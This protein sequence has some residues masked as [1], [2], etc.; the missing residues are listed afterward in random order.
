[1]ILTRDLI[2]L[3]FQNLSL[4]KVRSALTSL[5]VIFGVG[6]VIAMLAIAEG[7]KRRALEQ[8]ERMG[9]DRIMVTGEKP[10][11]E[12]IDATNS[13]GSSTITYGLT[14]ADKENI[15]KMDNVADVIAIWDQDLP[16][17]RGLN[18]VDVKLVGVEPGFLALS[19]SEIDMGRWF[20]PVDYQSRNPVCVIGSNAKKKLFSLSRRSVIG[21][22][23]QV[24]QQPYRVVGVLSNTTGAS[25]G[26]LKSPNDMIF[27]PLTLAR[28]L[29]GNNTMA[30]PGGRLPEFSCFI[31]QVH[32]ISYIDNTARR[33]QAYLKGAHG[34]KNDWKVVVPL[35]LLKQSEETQNIFTIVMS[36]I[37]SISLI[38]GGIGIMNI[39]LAGV[40][41]RR[42]EIGTRRALGA[43]KADILLQFLLE[44]VFLTTLGGL[45]GIAVGIGLSR[46]VAVY[47]SMPV[48]YSWWSIVL[49]LCISCFVGVVF[50]T[51]PAWKA[52]QQNPIDVLRSE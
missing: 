3:A 16:V 46:L 37:A 25:Y 28:G 26:E 13:S 23:I 40:Y 30:N 36:S 42:K 5:G 51:Y 33:L 9:I 6:S 27:T 20:S 1:M 45:L 4:H 15:L 29:Y 35:E 34:E 18:R 43:Q 22:L 24:G 31:I 8:I 49:S 48:I 19:G 38:V 17:Y 44:T 47:A 14:A 11:E 32:D 7:A 41:E 12:N 50:G 21:S 2:R 52:A 39:M 10:T